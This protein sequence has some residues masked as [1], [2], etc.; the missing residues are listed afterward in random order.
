[1]VSE[2]SWFRALWKTKKKHDSEPEKLRVGVLAFEVT[3]LMCKLV[4]LWKSLSDD[5]VSRLRDEIAN[6][7]GIKKLVSE[8]DVYISKL[9]C[10]E[11]SENL[12]NMASTVTRL[13]KKCRDPLLRSFELAFD[14]LLKLSSD[15][16]G[17][18]LSWKKMGRKVKKMERF[19]AINANLYREMET[20]SDL[21][22]TV[23]RMKVGCGNSVDPPTD[24]V[25]LLLEYERKVTRKKD[26]VK[27]LREV[28]LW[29][30]SYD[31][32]IFLLA[33]SVFT[34]F[35]RV[36]DVFGMNDN[37][38]VKNLK[39]VESDYI[40]RSQSVAFSHSSVHPTEYK[41]S[42]FSSEPFESHLLA[43]SGPVLKA[44][45]T[46]TFFS[47]PLQNP[48]TVS[49]AASSKTLNFYSGPMEMSSEKPHSIT[50]PNKLQKW[51]HLRGKLQISKATEKHPTP[52]G[53]LLAC[54]ASSP[55]LSSSRRLLIEAPPD[56]LGAAALAHHY[57]NIIIV[58]EKF[59]ASP[60]L[61]AP[62]AREDLYNMLPASIR[63]AL[64]AKLKPY[65]K[66]LNLVG[67]DMSLAE[68]W[69]EAMLGILG[70]LVPLA[71]HMLRW[72]SE[73]SFEH[74]RSFVSRT[75]NVFLVQ[76]LYYANQEKTE[77]TIAEL[78]VGLNYLWGYSREITAKAIEKH[79]GERPFEEDDDS[80]E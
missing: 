2:S 69:N 64:R 27:Y 58:I 12:R 80:D 43:K 57:A 60:H 63:A 59:V 45:K 10:S 70:W 65:A 33:R 37:Q 51:W 61:I 79:A 29:N 48:N 68:E 7:L 3:S 16:Y 50:R 54:G 19:V 31:Y 14:E 4:H 77:A 36:R 25:V 18:Q 32:T 67:H 21:E 42:R 46:S 39:L 38:E 22:R 13:S 56:T 35:S 26:E 76:T 1:M 9:I 55:Y 49:D 28:S 24:T 75:S 71:H 11:I 15:P 23:R 6:S 78:L 41:L 40:F 30:R 62:D 20:L 5:Q 73:R 44:T 72:Q 52:V 8:D 66:T 34:I 53:P 47:G 74:H 17:W